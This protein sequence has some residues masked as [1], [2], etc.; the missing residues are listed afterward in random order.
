MLAAG[1]AGCWEGC[2]ARACWAAAR[3]AAATVAPWAEGLV[4]G[5]LL[6]TVRPQPGCPT[7][8]AMA[9]AAASRYQAR[10]QQGWHRELRT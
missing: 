8:R 1:T 5:G 10:I 7:G 9:L 6:R 4:G 3:S 2:P